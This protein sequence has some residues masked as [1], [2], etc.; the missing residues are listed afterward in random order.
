MAFLKSLPDSSYSIMCIEDSGNVMYTGL[1]RFLG[2]HDQVAQ[3]DYYDLSAS[4][5]Y[6]FLRNRNVGLWSELEIQEYEDQVGELTP[7]FEYEYR[8]VDLFD[9]AWTGKHEARKAGYIPPRREQIPVAHKADNIT[10]ASG[11]CKICECRMTLHQN[12]S[13][14]ILA[15]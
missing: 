1:S 3:E 5:H 12:L 8:V 10:V 7:R 15:L 11:H 6:A 2:H 13:V 4:R 9:E 14:K